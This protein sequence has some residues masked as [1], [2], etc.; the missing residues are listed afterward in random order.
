M[1]SHA[2]FV[3]QH[4]LLEYPSSVTSLVRHQA[5]EDVKPIAFCIEYM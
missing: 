2:D 1:M 3:I 4:V 5:L